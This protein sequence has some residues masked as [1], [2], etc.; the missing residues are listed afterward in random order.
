MKD[1]L[2]L[3]P[4]LGAAGTGIL[5]MALDLL[6]G[7]SDR[8]KAFLAWVTALGLCLCAVGA[9]ALWQDAP[10]LAAPFFKDVVIPD[11]FT[12]FFG[13]LALFGAAAS[14]LLAVDF[15]PAHA[16]EPG[17]FY[18][19]F[20]FCGAGA[21]TFVAA[22]DVLTMFLGLEIMSLAAYALAASAKD[23]PFGMEAGLKYFVLGSIAA[24]LLLFG[25]AFLYG[26]TGGLAIHALV[27]G[28]GQYRLVALVLLIT[29]LGFKV[30]MVPFHFWTP[31]VY[32]GAPTPVSG[33]MA[34][35]IKAAG[36]AVLARLLLSLFHDQASLPVMREMLLGLSV[37]TMVVGNILGIV[38]DD[39]KRILAY[40][41]IAHAGYLLLGVY[42]G[43]HGAQALLNEAVPFYLVV[44]VAGTIGAFGVISLVGRRGD[45]TVRLGDLSG[46]ARTEPLLA[47]SLLISVLSLAGVPPFAGFM[48]KFA[49]FKAILAADPD[50]NLVFVMV[51]VLNSL[52]ALYYY[53]RVL[54]HAYFHDQADGT[55]LSSTT[56]RLI[57]VLAAAVSLYLG[58]FPGPTMSAS[59]AAANVAVM[60][61]DAAFGP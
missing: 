23:S 5:V 60:F 15:V 48:A 30:A 12:A 6:T 40:S 59:S 46:L 21:L 52:I 9:M 57:I 47:V 11:R 51:A 31:D 58:L 7:R 1:L 42:A 38:Q 25:F 49:L 2:I 33:L 10:A 3:A 45:A 35:T 17:P 36:F 61:G 28:G 41:S 27:K 20:A 55:P 54:V 56:A 53:L 18:A 16:I 29:A 34:S 44:Y 50:R 14:A 43:R 22:G 37:L 19:L 24:A 32:Q 13:A 4:L 39:V 8:R 26:E